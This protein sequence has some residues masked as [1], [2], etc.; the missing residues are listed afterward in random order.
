MSAFLIGFGLLIMGFGVLGTA[1][2]PD[3]LMRLHAS[4]KCGVTGT[5]TILIG[6]AIRSGSPALAVRLLL[7]IAFLFWT[8]P[9]IPHILSFCHLKNSGRIPGEEESL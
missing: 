5:V 7:L 8:S 1:I 3:L 2:L 6:L 9:M 4:T